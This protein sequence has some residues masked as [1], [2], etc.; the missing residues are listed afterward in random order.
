MILLSTAYFPNIQYF[1]K[2]ANNTEIIVE[3][4]ENY[5]KKSY[6]NRCEILGANGILTLSVP[7]ERTGDKLLISNVKIDYSED[8]QKN[9]LKAI[10]AAYGLSPFYEF[11][12]DDIKAIFE[13][14]HEKLFELNKNILNTVTEITGIETKIEYS[15]NFIDIEENS[16]DFRFSIHPKK[17]MQ[18]EDNKFIANKYIQTFSEKFEFIKNLSILDLIFNLGPECLEYLHKT[19]KPPK[20]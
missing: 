3:G 4:N 6:R 13:T 9:H 11:Y 15:K 12:I 8:W 10:E 19:K 18:I 20:V 16:K 1:S 14:K 2:L 5:Q 17:K 7:V